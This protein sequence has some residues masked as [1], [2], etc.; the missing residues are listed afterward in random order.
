MGGTFWLFLRPLW[1]SDGLSFRFCPIALLFLA[2]PCGSVAPLYTFSLTACAS[3][4][5]LL[6]D[7]AHS[8][9][10]FSFSRLCGLPTLYNHRLLGSLYWS[11]LTRNQL[12]PFLY[13][14]FPFTALRPSCS[15]QSPFTWIS[16]LALLPLSFLLNPSKTSSPR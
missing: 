2:T 16:V 8:R 1:L 15:T 6:S 10:R 13:S 14:A 7:F 3:L 5:G 9:A 12:P 4:A 11:Y